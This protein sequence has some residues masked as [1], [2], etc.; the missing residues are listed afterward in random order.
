MVSSEKS[1]LG[2]NMYLCPED[3]LGEG[4]VAPEIR[5]DRS[6]II[7]SVRGG[8]VVGCGLDFLETV[9]LADDDFIDVGAS[10]E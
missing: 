6:V 8:S 1:D 10:R 7:C 5:V 9:R 4:F 3:A 2:R